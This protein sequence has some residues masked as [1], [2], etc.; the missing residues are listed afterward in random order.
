M[1]RHGD[2]F[3]AACDSIP[4]EAKPLPHLILAEGEITGHA[5]RILERDAAE[6]F[7]GA[8]QLYLRVRGNG[9]TLTHEEHRAISIPQGT[10]RVWI[11]REY[12]PR[13]IRRVID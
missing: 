3:I 12:T 1:W 13:E 8:D 9:A 5:H 2:V 4:A 10:Y 6:L 7:R 11:Q